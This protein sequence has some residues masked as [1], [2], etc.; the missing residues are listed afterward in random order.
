MSADIQSTKTERMPYVTGHSTRHHYQKVPRDYVGKDLDLSITKKSVT[1]YYFYC[2]ECGSFD[3]YFEGQAWAKFK[4]LAK[5]TSCLWLIPLFFSFGFFSIGIFSFLLTQSV[6]LLVCGG[7]GLAVSF[8]MFIFST[9]FSDPERAKAIIKATSCKHCGTTYRVTIP[10]TYSYNPRN[11]TIQDYKN[12][13]VKQAA[14]SSH[15]FRT[16][17]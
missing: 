17:N 16:N 11:Y 7:F 9:F 4:S 15:G 2:G 13:G 6:S 12:S 14:L 10:I 5:K 3:I 1:K 8:G